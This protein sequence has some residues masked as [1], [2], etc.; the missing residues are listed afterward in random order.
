[1]NAEPAIIADTSLSLQLRIIRA[2]ASSTAIETGQPI[3]DLES[4]LKAQ[5]SKFQQLALAS[6]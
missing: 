6:A 4:L 1:M 3:K 5:T 2:V